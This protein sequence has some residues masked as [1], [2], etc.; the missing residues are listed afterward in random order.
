[1]NT[2]PAG[3]TLEFMLRVIDPSADPAAFIA[4]DGVVVTAGVITTFGTL[5]IVLDSQP[6]AV[7][8]VT[9]ISTGQYKVAFSGLSATTVNTIETVTVNGE[10]D[11]TAWDEFVIGVSI[12]PS[13][14]PANVSQWNDE[15]VSDL[16]SGSVPA[17]IM[18]VD[19]T[20]G[21]AR[22]GTDGDTL[23]TLSDQIDAIANLGSGPHAVTV[24]VDDGTDPLQGARVRY[25]DGG[26]NVHTY[27]TDAN[28]QI[29]FNLKTADYT[30]TISKDGYSFSG[31]THDVSGDSTPTY[32]MTAVANP[33]PSDPTMTSAIAKVIDH[34]GNHIE[35][36][37]V[38]F[39]VVS[40]PS[41]EGV[42]FDDSKITVLS[43]S[44][45][46]ITVSLFKGASYRLDLQDGRTKKI[47]ISISS[48]D[49]INLP[50]LVV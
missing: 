10:I 2:W 7:P 41:G 49:S 20:S 1:M 31:T 50:N 3:T 4:P 40:S 48:G 16:E 18:G 33:S 36:Y 21:V 47:E 22:E 44:E 46:Y 5:S 9:E 34:E 23:E 15:A 35:N 42:W 43:D 26:V 13:T 39:T 25:S 8:T 11:G 24:T 37:E 30:V 27:T 6:S 14:Y 19:P 45:G 12:V 29:P 32:S 28:G 38:S 17:K